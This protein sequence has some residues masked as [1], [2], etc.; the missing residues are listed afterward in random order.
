[1]WIYF[2]EQVWTQ[3]DGD[4]IR[5]GWRTW[6]AARQY[7]DQYHYGNSE[8]QHYPTKNMEIDVDYI[9]L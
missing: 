8:L 1:M 4:W 9:E 2:I 5:I 6:E 7:W 3:S